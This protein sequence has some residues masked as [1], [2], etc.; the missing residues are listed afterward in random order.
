MLIKIRKQ[1]MKVTRICLLFLLYFFSNQAMALF[2]GGIDYQVISGN[3]KPTP[4]CKNKQKAAKQATTGYRFKK[5]TKVL[6]QQ[7]GYG[8]NFSAVEDSGELVCEPCDGKPES[9]T[10]NYQCYVKNITLKCRLIRRGW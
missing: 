3:L 4:G 10:E 5:Q 8:W 6:C 9:S 7:I 2:Q 1:A